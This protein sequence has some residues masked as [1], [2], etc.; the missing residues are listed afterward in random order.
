MNVDGPT[1]GPCGRRPCTGGRRAD[2]WLWRWR[3]SPLRRREDVIEAWV[4]LVTWVVLV[5]GGAVT[6]LVTAHA[7]GQE[8]ARQRADRHAVRAVL[9]ADVPSAPS[10]AGTESYRAS[11]PVRWTAP[12]GS[13][14][15]GRTLVATGL[16]AGTPL[17]L[18]QDGRGV[19]ASAPPGGAEAVFE[20][21]LFGAGAALGLAGVVHAAGATA[22]WRLDRR[23]LNGWATEWERV[24]PRW[25]RKTR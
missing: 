15:T 2:R 10:S 14:R 24:G 19:L 8:F 16:R 5:V 25:A 9:L 21:A 23:R 13:T 1:G 18:W 3:R 6:G 22:R 12:D 20:A 7:A 17:A 11:A 4:L